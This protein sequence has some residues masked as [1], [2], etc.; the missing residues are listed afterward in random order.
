MNSIQHFDCRGRRRVIAVAGGRGISDCAAYS[1]QSCTSDLGQ[2]LE[3]LC[4][5][6]DAFVKHLIDLSSLEESC[7]HEYILNKERTEYNTFYSC[8]SM[9]IIEGVL[10]KLD[11]FICGRVCVS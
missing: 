3:L 5:T 11:R 6:F 10:M 9:E 7:L 8:I 1:Q 2:G 4:H